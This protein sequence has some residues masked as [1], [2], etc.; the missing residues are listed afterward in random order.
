VQLTAWLPGN[1]DCDRLGEIRVLW[2]VFLKTL[3]KLGKPRNTF[4]NT[5][6]PLYG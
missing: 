5:H 1:T 6:I 3:I 4:Q 2:E